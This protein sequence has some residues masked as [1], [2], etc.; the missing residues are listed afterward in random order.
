MTQ[1]PITPRGANIPPATKLARLLRNTIDDARRSGT[2]QRVH[3][4]KGAEVVAR[5]RDGVV[6]LTIKRLGVDVG[7]VELRTFQRDAGVPTGAERIPAEG[8]HE[9]DGWRWVCFRWTDRGGT[10]KPTTKKSPQERMD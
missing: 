7:A 10:G 3:L 4:S 5:V 2:D 8:Q 6:M 1:K 9:R